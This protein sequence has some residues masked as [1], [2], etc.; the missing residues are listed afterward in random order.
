M[1]NSTKSIF[2]SLFC[3]LFLGSCNMFPKHEGYTYNKKLGYYYQLLAFSDTYAT[4]HPG[5]VVSVSMY[6]NLVDTDSILIQENLDVVAKEE[7]NLG[8]PL[9]FLDIH[10]GDSLSFIVPKEKLVDQSFI[11]EIIRND[12]TADVQFTVFVNSIVDSL[13]F[14]E[15]MKEKMLW[16]QA[17][18]DYET[19]LIQQYFKRTREKYTLLRSGIYKRIIKRGRGKM[20][21]SGDAVSIAF[22]GSLLDGT[23][24]SNLMTLDFRLGAEMQVIKGIDKCIR[25]MRKGERAKVIIP[26]EFAWGESGSSDGTIPPYTP[27][28]F[29]IQLK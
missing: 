8:L 22:Q 18:Q 16:K 9:L 23:I 2:V 29:D 5:D 25:T 15:Q 14:A 7:Q 20:P 12:T 10:T 17:K 26:S 21:Q 3:V 1:R 6:F 27:V 24:I 11:P 19:F 28:V 13:V 4:A